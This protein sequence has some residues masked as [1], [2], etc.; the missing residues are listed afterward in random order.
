MRP[1]LAAAGWRNLLFALT[2]L[3]CLIFLVQAFL[4]PGT[5]DYA[6]FT[7]QDDARQFLTWMAR[8]ENPGAMA[9]DLLADYWQS[10]APVAW[11]WLYQVAAALGIAPVDLARIVPPVLLLVSAYATW[12]VAMTM[13]GGRPAAAFVAAAFVMALL[14]HEDSIYSAT[15]RAFSPPLFLLFLD[16]LL[17]G[18]PVRILVS[19][20]LLAAIYP[21]TALV[22]LTMLGLSYLRVRPRPGVEI[23]R[24]SVATVLAAT[25]AVAVPVLSLP[26]Q[27]ERWEPVLT[28]E[29][30]LEL[31]NLG[32]A[33][34]RSS[35]VNQDGS[36]GWLCSARM[37]FLP[38]IVP[39]WSSRWAALPNAL[40]LVPLLVL[41]IGAALRPKGPR[42]PNLIYLWA[43]LA[44]FG[45]WVVATIFAFKLH[46]PARYP[47]RVLSILEWLAIGQMIGLWLAARSEQG[48]MTAWPKAVAAVLAL[49]FVISFATPTPGLRRP[50]DAGAMAY[51]QRLPG[52]ARIAG[53]AQDLDAVPALTGKRTLATVEHAI[54]YHWGYFSQVKQRLEHSLAAVASDDPYVLPAFVRRYDATHLVVDRALAER[55]QVPD[56][57]AAVVPVAARRAERALG[58]R[59]APVLGAR[60]E[61]LLYTGPVVLIYDARC[62]ATR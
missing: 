5:T 31:P 37:G 19:L 16:G 42:D 7:I 14:V 30:A 32:S 20:G 58:G 17:R 61:C 59:A 1:A 34:G 24:R 4:V 3:T 29:Q 54:P 46:L 23:T 52:N 2:G 15:P 50:Q 45:W 51:L 44:G 13:C 36:V 18:R 26:G 57:Y 33:D 41:G 8:L 48:R 35:I 9:G 56:G 62:L 21:T 53:V 25:L 12:R 49:L 6:P 40:L 47:Q 22:G 28:V 11:R 10:V 60:A 43:L 27:T 39:C 55:A 38:E